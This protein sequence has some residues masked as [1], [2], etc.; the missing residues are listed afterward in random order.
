MDT[1]ELDKTAECILGNDEAGVDRGGILGFE[2]LLA[3][4]MALEVGA[5]VPVEECI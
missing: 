4:V 1:R 3:G 5:E 2:L